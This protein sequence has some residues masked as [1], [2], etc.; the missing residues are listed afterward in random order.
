MR[1]SSSG[2]AVRNTRSARHAQWGP[3]GW[4]RA[5]P[6]SATTWA[7]VRVDVAAIRCTKNAGPAS[8]RAGV[9]TVVWP[10][11]VA[12]AA[13]APRWRVN[14]RLGHDAQEMPGATLAPRP[15]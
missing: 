2:S 1:T 4:P 10:S 3:A 12:V 15:A 7:R 8:A 6:V 5:F 11:R 9:L 13:N 14:K